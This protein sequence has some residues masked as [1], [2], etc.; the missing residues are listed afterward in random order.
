MGFEARAGR[1]FALVQ[2]VRVYWRVDITCLGDVVVLE[3]EGLQRGEL[4]DAGGEVL[5][6]VVLEVQD[7]KVRKMRLVGLN[8]AGLVKCREG[9]ASDQR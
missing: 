4:A 8:R 9:E 6:T 3:V 7:L 1:E 5:E 2:F